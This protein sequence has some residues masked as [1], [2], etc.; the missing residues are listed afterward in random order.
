MTTLHLPDPRQYPDA[1]LSNR[2]IHLTQ[3]VLAARDDA[4]RQSQQ[5][6]LQ[7][8]L[9]DLLERDDVLLLSVALNMAPTRAAYLELWQALRAAVEQ[10][11]GRH[12]VIFALPL[13]LV[14]GSRQRATLPE[15]VEDVDALNALL[16]SQQ[17]FA[18]DA[19]VFL[20]GKLLH[21]DALMEISPAQLYR[22]TRQLADAARGLPLELPASAVTV[23]EEGVFLRYL[24]GVAIQQPGQEAPVNFDSK[25]GVWGLPMMKFLG[26]QLKV[27]GV[28]LFPIARSP[29]PLMQAIAAGNQARLEVA[30]QVYA[31]SLL[32]K[33]RTEGQQPVA[34]V[35]SH[36]S[37]EIHFTLTAGAKPGASDECFVWPLSPQD[38]VSRIEQ[39]FRD[40]MQECQVEQVIFETTVQPG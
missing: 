4:E 21:P 24:L 39:D 7:D 18:A 12:A 27:D 8:T 15:R 30:L 38:S 1:S 5:S 33:L 25:V 3:S 16:R 20:S 22:Y 31:S 2:L 36:G 26:D 29:A 28:T 34:W 11:S 19:E 40:L 10:A 17:I 37:N 23:Q 13:V 14:A 9:R 6:V 35:A 32:R